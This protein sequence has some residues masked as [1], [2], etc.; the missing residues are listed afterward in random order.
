MSKRG[1]KIL[2]CILLIVFVLNPLEGEGLS[3]GLNFHYGKTFSKNWQ[4]LTPESYLVDEWDPSF[5]GY[6]IQLFYKIK[7]TNIGLEFGVNR[8]FYY[9]KTIPSESVW[10]GKKKIFFHRKNI[11]AVMQYRINTNIFIQAG[12]GVY[13]QTQ[14]LG[15]MLSFRNHIKL[16]KSLVL[17]IFVRGD[18][19]TW[20]GMPIVLSVGTGVVIN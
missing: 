7:K 5:V 15:F 17:P 3:L 4:F 1:N 10:W 20:K 2:L 14:A 13:Y 12:M 9:F 11:L 16:T 18:F 8:F 6:D 19:I